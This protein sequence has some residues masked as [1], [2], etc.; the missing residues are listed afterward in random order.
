MR[1]ATLLQCP[2]PC[3]VMWQVVQ[4]RPLVATPS[5][6]VLWCA[7]QLQQ[8]GGIGGALRKITKETFAL[9]K[10]V[11]SSGKDAGEAPFLC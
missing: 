3:G 10:D 4:P 9:I 5:S 7:P 1:R 2:L 11:A 8:S 6:V